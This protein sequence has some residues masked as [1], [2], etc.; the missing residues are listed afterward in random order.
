MT[1]IKAI[2]TRLGVAD[3]TRSANFYSTVLGFDVGTMWP[4]AAPEFAILHR[5][6]LRLQ[7]GKRDSAEG[8]GSTLC[9]DVAGALDLHSTIKDKVTIDWGPE[10][11]FYGRREF[12]FKDPDGH[13][14]I[15]SE[16]TD[17][18]VTCPDE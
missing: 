14:I 18:P 9:L 6:G 3:V 11:Y 2:E 5:D 4:E 15:V 13:G 17:D 16:V 1:T 10:V 7:L 12:S 8:S